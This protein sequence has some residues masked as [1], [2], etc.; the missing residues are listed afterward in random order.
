MTPAMIDRDGWIPWAFVAFFGVVLAANG[1][2]IWI[3]F[4][5]S[6][7]MLRSHGCTTRRRASGALT[8]ATCWSGTG[9]P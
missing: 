5:T 8:L 2:M 6:G 1:A 3:A 9:L 7:T 4:T